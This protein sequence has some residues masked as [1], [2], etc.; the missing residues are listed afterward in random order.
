[1]KVAMISVG[2]GQKSWTADLPD[3]TVEAIAREARKNLM[4][5]DVYAEF[6][7][8]TGGS[9]YAGMRHVGRFEIGELEQNP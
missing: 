4:S 7:S 3:P 6:E 9:I 2:R 1:M 5:R 8:D